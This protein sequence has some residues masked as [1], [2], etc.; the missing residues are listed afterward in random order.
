MAALHYKQM[1]F[2]ESSR[3]VEV[4]D[5]IGAFKTRF[6]NLEAIIAHDS[7][8]PKVGRT[9]FLLVEH[10]LPQVRIKPGCVLPDGRSQQEGR[11]SL[12]YISYRED[13]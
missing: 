11:L 12:Y 8:L 3:C 5:F 1:I 9:S 6:L 13:K 10:K 2:G 7:G 4:Y